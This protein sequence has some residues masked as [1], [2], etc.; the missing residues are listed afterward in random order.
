LIATVPAHASLAYTCD[1]TISAG[2]CTTLNSSIAGLYD[3]NFS[4]I[5][6]NAYIKMGNTGLGQ[7]TTALSAYSYTTFRNA[8]NADQ[9]SANDTTGFNASAPVA[10]PFGGTVSR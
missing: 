8:L 5:T 9:T 7:S 10:N 3:S 2:V 6:L 1:A 4:D